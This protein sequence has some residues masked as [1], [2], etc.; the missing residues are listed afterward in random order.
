MF[1]SLLTT[2]MAN[3]GSL[4][5]G[6]LILSVFFAGS[7]LQ[8]ERMR[9]QEIRDALEEIE[10]ATQQSLDRVEEINANLGQEDARLVSEIAETYEI[11]ATLNEQERKT[12]AG[13]EA[14]GRAAAQLE[15]VRQAERERLRKAAEFSF[16]N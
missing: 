10:K 11:L 15:N 12:R 3:P 8:G 2:L 7:M 6:A 4:S 5:L 13:L 9:N 1:G 16:S 14:S